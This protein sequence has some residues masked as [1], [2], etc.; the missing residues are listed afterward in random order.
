MTSVIDILWRNRI[1]GKS[2]VSFW[3]EAINM[4]AD[5]FQE[6][7][8]FDLHDD[9]PELWAPLDPDPGPIDTIIEEA[10]G[11]KDVAAGNIKVY[12]EP[13]ALH[14][15]CWRWMLRL[16]G[17]A[18]RDAGYDLEQLRDLPEM[19][20]HPTLKFL[21][22][23]KVMAAIGPLDPDEDERPSIESWI[24]FQNNPDE[25]DD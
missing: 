9:S 20:E 4:L 11:Q 14:R 23:D 13:N 21:D 7:R 19:V 10:D 16:V 22:P 6:Q 15:L 5:S 18:L 24:H 25:Y 12:D 2:V 8:N 17:E 1:D 3:T